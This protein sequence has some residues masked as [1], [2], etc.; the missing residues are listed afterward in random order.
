[1]AIEVLD[2]GGTVITG[3]ADIHFVG[4][5]GARRMMLLE[6]ET[7]LKYRSGVNL[8]Q[9]CRDA[10]ISSARLKKDVVNDLERYLKKTYD[11][12]GEVTTW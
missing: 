8:F 12:H 2:G 11:W 6:I 10:G 4:L 5:L 1:M 9:D 3:R 7:G